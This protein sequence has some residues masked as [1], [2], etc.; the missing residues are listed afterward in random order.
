MN[1]KALSTIRGK[2]RKYNGSFGPAIQQY[3]ENADAEGYESPEE[4]VSG[5]WLPFR[6]YLR[7]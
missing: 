7:S 2:I 1:S 3:R 6:C 5:F 4:E